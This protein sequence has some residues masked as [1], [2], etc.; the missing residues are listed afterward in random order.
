MVR[1]SSCT[2]WVQVGNRDVDA[3]VS[4]AL[5]CP[6]SR[7]QTEPSVDPARI[8]T[9]RQRRKALRRGYELP[10][11]PAVHYADFFTSTTHEPKRGQR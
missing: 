9:Y 1:S 10:A 6:M 7:Y 2:I 3:P 8:I 11:E 4:D 5:R